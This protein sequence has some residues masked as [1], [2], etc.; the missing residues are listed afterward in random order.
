MRGEDSTVGSRTNLVASIEFNSKIRN[1]SNCVV[2]ATTEQLV[3]YGDDI[4]LLSPSVS[5]VN[6]RSNRF[7]AATTRSRAITFNQVV[8]L[9]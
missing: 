6:V 1:E 7:L 8:V 2:A 4:R 5:V 3:S 9:E